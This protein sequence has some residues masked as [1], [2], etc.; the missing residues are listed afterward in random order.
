MVSVR[1]IAV[2]GLKERFFRDA[3]AEYEKRMKRFA[4]FKVVEIKEAHI[5]DDPSDAEVKRALSEEGTRILDAVKSGEKQ[6]EY[7]F[8]CA[9][10]GKALDSEKLAARMGDIINSGSGCAAFVIGGS[11]GLDKAVT[12]RAD[13]LLSFSALTFPHQLFRV[14]LMEQIYRAFKILNGEKYH[15]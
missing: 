14:M 6:N 7:V 15:K 10:D 9:I 13:M 5:P 4:N 3:C 1:V 2:G 12:Q 11:H 8:A